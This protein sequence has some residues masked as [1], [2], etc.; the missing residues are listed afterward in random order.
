M[1]QSYVISTHD[2]D[3]LIKFLLR[4]DVSNL[5]VLLSWDAHK[6]HTTRDKL[7]I[8][9]VVTGTKMDI[10]IVDGARPN[11]FRVRIT[12]IVDDLAC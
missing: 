11:Y 1:L 9:S 3:Y 6:R 7:T 10:M 8:A 5:N 2:F 4:V 12:H